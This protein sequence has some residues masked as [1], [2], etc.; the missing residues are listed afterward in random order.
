MKNKSFLTFCGPVLLAFLVLLGQGRAFTARADETNGYAGSEWSRLDT[1][2]VLLE[3]AAITAEKFPN[4]DSAT[5][6]G[7]SVRRMIPAERNHKK[8]PRVHA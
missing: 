3:A 6:D 4:C 2:K 5:V 8:L 1:A 7:K